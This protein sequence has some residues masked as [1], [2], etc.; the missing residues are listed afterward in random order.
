MRRHDRRDQAL[1]RAH[2][3]AQ[4]TLERLE[5]GAATAAEAR[6]AGDDLERAQREALDANL[7]T[8]ARGFSR[9]AT[10]LAELLRAAAAL[11]AAGQPG[12]AQLHAR[13]REARLIDPLTGAA[14]LEGGRHQGEPIDW[15][16]SRSAREAHED[17]LRVRDLIERLRAAGGQ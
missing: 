3:H 2:R 13:L 14:L 7:R 10:E 9:I 6:A 8:G 17:A 15:K 4:A 16:T 5:T 12:A 1:R 11:D